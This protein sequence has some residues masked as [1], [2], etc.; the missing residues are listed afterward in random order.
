[1]DSYR[2][3]L[4]IVKLISGEIDDTTLSIIDPNSESIQETNIK[5]HFD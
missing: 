3:E 1:M 2:T 4:H 5:Y